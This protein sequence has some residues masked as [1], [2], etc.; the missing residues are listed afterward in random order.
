M[1]EERER[2][3]VSEPSASRGIAVFSSFHLAELMRDETVR[4]RVGCDVVA[5]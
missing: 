2:K 5:H 3:L 1:H 4:D